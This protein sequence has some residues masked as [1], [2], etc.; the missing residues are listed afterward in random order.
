MPKTET[1]TWLGLNQRTNERDL[2]PEHSPD[3]SNAF[4]FDGQLGKLGPR[5][6]KTF[7]NRPGLDQGIVMYRGYDHPNRTGHFV[8]TADGTILDWDGTDRTAHKAP[9]KTAA[10]NLTLSYPTTSATQASTAFTAFNAEDYL[11]ARL[12]NFRVSYNGD[13]FTPGQLRFVVWVGFTVDGTVQYVTS[14]HFNDNNTSGDNDFD[15][16]GDYQYTHYG[17]MLPNK[18]SITKLAVK[19]DAISLAGVSGFAG[20]G[21]LGN[22]G[23]RNFYAQVRCDGLV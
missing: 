21:N 5:L 10:I 6:G 17:I 19:I 16:T 3:T 20:W 7:G 2:T 4:H 1:R 23:A 12:D 14:Q 22:L 18:G 9:S 15:I 13:V 11:Y 8:Y